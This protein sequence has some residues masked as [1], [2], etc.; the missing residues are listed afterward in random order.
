[1]TPTPEE[2]EVIRD[3]LPYQ[4]TSKDKGIAKT[5]L[6]ALFQHW[7]NSG[8]VREGRMFVYHDIYVDADVWLA[9]TI[10]TTGFPVLILKRGE[11]S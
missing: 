6:T 7:K 1:M 2:I 3:C 8:M 4:L 11:Q 9:D 5:I 10:R